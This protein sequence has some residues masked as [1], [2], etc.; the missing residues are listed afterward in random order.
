VLDVAGPDA[1]A[2]WSALPM[3]RRRAVVKAL[4]DV[5]IHRTARGNQYT[6]FDPES[7]KVRR[8]V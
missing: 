3:T 7:V 2:R 8:L 6:A 1:S 4:V 5:R